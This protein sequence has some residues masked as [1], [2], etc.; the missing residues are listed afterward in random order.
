MVLVVFIRE[1]HAGMGTI[2]SDLLA[3]VFVLSAQQLIQRLIEKR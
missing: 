1:N 2:Q 3:M